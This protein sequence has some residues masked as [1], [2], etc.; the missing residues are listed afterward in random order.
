MDSTTPVQFLIIAVCISHVTNTLAKAMN[1]TILPSPKV[2]SWAD[3][4]L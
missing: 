2:N 1:L 4:A 3:W